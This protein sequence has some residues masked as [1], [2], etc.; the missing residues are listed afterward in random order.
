MSVYRVCLHHHTNPRGDGL[1]VALSRLRAY[2]TLHIKRGTVSPEGPPEIDILL[3]Y[4]DNLDLDHHH[5]PQGCVRPL[6][7]R[8]KISKIPVQ[9]SPTMN[10]SQ[11]ANPPYFLKGV[12][13][14]NLA[15]FR[16]FVKD[17]FNILSMDGRFCWFL[18]RFCADLVG[19]FWGFCSISR[20]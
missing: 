8:R 9:M 14:V 7:G 15:Q 11:P 3:T 4:I 20:I 1:P 18:C 12:R 16:Y 2:R 5:N 6:G 17:L 13:Y 10:K 19:F